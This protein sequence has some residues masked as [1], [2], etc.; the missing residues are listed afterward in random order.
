[1]MLDTWNLQRSRGVH[2]LVF[3]LELQLLKLLHIIKKTV[4]IVFL[5]NHLRR[6]DVVMHLLLAIFVIGSLLSL[7]PEY[8]IRPMGFY[9]L[10]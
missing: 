10:I 8:L 3:S 4:M 9:D 7:S 5:L 6:K 1:M 2:E